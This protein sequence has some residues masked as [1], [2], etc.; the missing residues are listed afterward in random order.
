MVTL[1]LCVKRRIVSNLISEKGDT[2]VQECITLNLK[3]KLIRS[4]L[5]FL[6]V[7]SPC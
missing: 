4:N 5:S 7:L 6:C 3:I 2:P 1:D